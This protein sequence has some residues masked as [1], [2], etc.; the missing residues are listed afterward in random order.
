VNFSSCER[1]ASERSIPSDLHYEEAAELR[2]LINQMIAKRT[3][4]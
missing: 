2:L 4:T 1:N 3:R